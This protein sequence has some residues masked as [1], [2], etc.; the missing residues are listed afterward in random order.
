M[1]KMTVVRAL[2]RYFNDGAGKRS[3]SEFNQE[4]K[5]LSA[6]EKVELAQGACDVMGW[7]LDIPK[8]T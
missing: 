5:A 7:E 1:E 3:I 2:N 4:V 8:T 6:D